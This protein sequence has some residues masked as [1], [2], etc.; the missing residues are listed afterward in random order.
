[1]SQHEIIEDNNNKKKPQKETGT[2]INMHYF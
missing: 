1:M 2:E